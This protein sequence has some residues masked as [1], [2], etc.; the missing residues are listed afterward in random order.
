MTRL[1]PRTVLFGADDRSEPQISPDGT[2]LAYLGP[3]DG[4][5]NVFVG[6]KEFRPITNATGRGVGGFVWAP[7]S[8][9]VIYAQDRGGDENWRLFA[10]D[11]D[12]GATKDL[13]PFEGVQGVVLATRYEHP[14][15]IAVLLNLD[16]SGRHDVYRLDL[17]TNELELAAR[18]DGFS[19]WVVDRDLR[20]RAAVKPRADGGCDLLVRDDERQGWRLLAE[21]GIDDALEVVFDSHPMWFSNDGRCLYFVTTKGADTAR[22]VRM[23]V[24]DGSI[25]EIASDPSYDIL[26]VAYHPRDR[27]PQAAFL[28]R[29]RSD[30]LIC[31][32]SVAGDL[33]ALRE[34][35][36]GDVLVGSRDDA[37]ERWVVAVV[38]DDD[39]GEFYLYDRREK[40][41]EL[42]YKRQPALSDFTLA[43]TEPFAFDARDGLRIHGYLTFPP[44]ADRDNLPAVVKVHGG[45]EYR[46]RWGFDAWTQFFANRG[47]LCVQVNYRGS[48]GY[49]KQFMAA[50][51][52]EWG[53]AMHHDVVDATAWVIEQRYADP[54]RIAM[55]GT[56]YGGYETLWCAATESEL[57]ACAVA[58][59]APV[60]LLTFMDDLPSYW[61][62][63]RAMYKHR[64][65][66]PD[67]DAE[68]LR[69]RSPLSHAHEIRKPLLVFYGD[70]D[71]RVRPG[72]A[73]QLAKALEASGIEHELHVL[74]DEGHFVTAL[75]A[76]ALDFMAKRTESFLAEH[77]GGRAEP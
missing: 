15:T 48:I 4:A 49:G 2:R 20:V 36:R 25:E 11:V 18:N 74:E 45:P 57:L 62:H 68:M 76:P 32:E 63:V 61:V 16:E 71:P 67:T 38:S 5:P 19:R 31:D 9:H 77:L 65:G 22:L 26:H 40:K 56:S 58:G 59:M 50:A 7:D 70:N 75:S 60:N 53:R 69:E 73:E 55:W 17:E 6:W 39:P 44:E 35:G 47:Y 10:T 29:D 1:I 28:T 8:R 51:R 23:S 12:S 13:T 54:R 3:H 52:K 21:F 37:D 41:A 66:D 72:E 33:E 30:Y 46:D 64:L 24:D 27:T 43:H 42:I 14:A 34:L